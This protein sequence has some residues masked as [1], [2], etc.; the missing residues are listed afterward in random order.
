MF[1][2]KDNIELILSGEVF[3][4]RYNIF[5]IIYQFRSMNVIEGIPEH[6][7]NCVFTWV[8]THTGRT[9]CV[10]MAYLK[11]ICVQCR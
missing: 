1:A 8:P 10:T 3:E 7:V 4:T 9:G 11:K 6:I 2:I 5:D